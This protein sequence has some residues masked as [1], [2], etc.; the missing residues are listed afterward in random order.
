MHD[1]CVAEI[2]QEALAG[3]LRA[4]RSRTGPGVSICAAVKANAYGHS[5]DI[6]LPVLQREGVERI[7]VANLNEALSARSKGWHRP[8]LLLGAAAGGPGEDTCTRERCRE[9]VAAGLHV[10]ISTVAEAKTLACEAARLHMP[11]RVEIKVDSGMGRMG[12]LIDNAAETITT[13]SRCPCVIVEGIYTH[14]A[15]ADEADQA[16]ARQQLSRFLELR[17]TLRRHQ[18]P[19]RAFHAANS[20]A[21]FRLPEACRGLDVARPG[22]CLYGYW[23]SPDERP[24]DLTPAMRVVSR[25]TA[26]RSVPAGHAVGY[27][28]TFRTSRPSVLG[29]V[30]IGYADGYRRALSNNAVMTLA[31]TRGLG[32]RTVP[33]VGRVSMD[34]TILDLTD[35][36]E[37]QLGDRVIVIDRDPAAPNSVE[38]IA[39]KLDTITYEITCLIGQRVRRVALSQP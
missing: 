30:P 19:V 28:C 24:A 16:F 7:A 22:I 13:I 37:V 5:V 21:I 23:D 39:R 33:V 12:L 14:F 11:A 26:V 36:G 1:N 31:A 27:G 6:V 32:R 9:A 10:T 2:G 17:E 15:S 18:I 29:V 4:I 20:A 8:I 25:L 3:N 38:A 35:A 34:Q